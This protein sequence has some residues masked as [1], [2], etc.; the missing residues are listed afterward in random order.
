MKYIVLTV[1]DWIYGIAQ[2]AAVFMAVF[3]GGI[4]LSLF[5]SARKRA[6]LRAW[7]FLIP[8]LVLFTA[9]E[10]I[11]ALVA[12]GVMKPNMWTHILPSGIL[13][14]LITSLII[15]L[16]VSKGWLK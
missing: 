2:L 3:A 6:V 16:S 10:I 5:D 7:L 14:L 1:Y 13:L 4:A 11:G 12:F 8:A 15:Q 9:E